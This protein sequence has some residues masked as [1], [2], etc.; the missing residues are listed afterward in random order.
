MHLSARILRNV[1][2]INHWQDAN[3]AEV[4]EGQSNEIYLRLVD[5]GWSTSAVPEQSTAFNEFPIRFI[6]Q[7]TNIAVT[8]IF[9]DIDE[10]SEFEVVGTQPFEQ[11]RSIFKFTLNSDQ[12][13]NPGNLLVSVNEDGN[14]RF[15][16]IQSAISTILTNRGGC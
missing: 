16:T 4:F 2:D 6:S 13:P 1:I 12:M 5:L 8:A 10:D 3:Q 15:F 7:A 11:D 14:V 9:R